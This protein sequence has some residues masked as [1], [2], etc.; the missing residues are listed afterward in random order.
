MENEKINYADEAFVT[1]TDANKT[2][3]LYNISRDIIVENFYGD[4]EDVFNVGEC[5]SREV[6]DGNLDNCINVLSNFI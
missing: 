1:V 5:D 4:K 6:L 2:E 3:I